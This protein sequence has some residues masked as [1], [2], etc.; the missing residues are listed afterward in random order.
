MSDVPKGWADTNFEMVLD[1]VQRG[2]SPKYADQS[3]LPVINQKCVRWWGIQEEFLK[4]IRPDQIDSYTE[5]RFVREG[6]V[7]WNSTGTGTIGRAALFRGLETAARTVV[8]GHVT[9]L[10]STKA[11]D[12]NYLFNFIKSPAV[13]NRIEDMQSGSTNQVELSKAEVLKTEI[14]LPPLVEQKRIVRKLDTLNAL[15]TSARDHL[16]V[17]S[18]L[19]DRFK[20]RVLSRELFREEV[21]FRKLGEMSSDVRYGTSAKCGYDPTGTPV[22]RIPNLQQGKID[23]EDL[24]TAHFTEKELEKLALKT[25]DVLVIRSNG[26]PD[27]VGR[28]ALVSEAETDFIFAGY[29]IRMRFDQTIALPEYVRLCFQSDEIRG[30]IEKGLKSTSGVNNINS[31]EL[32]ALEFPMP[33]VDEQREIIDRVEMAFEKIDRLTE[34]ASRALELV[35]HLDQRLLTKAFAGELVP[36]EPNDEPASVLLDRIREERAATPKQTTRASTERKKVNTSKKKVGDMN[37]KRR[38]QVSKTH[39]SSLLKQLGGSSPSRELWL[40]SDMDLNEFY[41]LLRDEV[42]AGRIDETQDKRTLVATN[43]A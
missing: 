5:E 37:E 14:P 28:V 6:D 30:K 1:Y 9:I 43:A 16:S 13:Q 7:L 12:P 3:D 8:D 21:A 22:L 36:Q 33:D 4:F 31:T 29:L 19:V 26:S 40:K 32:Q 24:K 17:V 15:T 27:L 39:L 23:H 38:S 20:L 2:K 10:R 41:M 11:I 18:K 42:S 35:D 34:E 25:G